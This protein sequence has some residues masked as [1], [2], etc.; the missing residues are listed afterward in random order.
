MSCELKHL[1]T[2]AVKSY[3]PDFNC[4]NFFNSMLEDKIR[5]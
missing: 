1:V 4:N 2:L 3:V 5:L